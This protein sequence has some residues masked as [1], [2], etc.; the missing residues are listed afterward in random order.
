MEQIIGKLS[1]IETTAET[2]MKDATQKKKALSAEMERHSK[3]FDTQLE[4]QTEEQIQEIRRNLEG[5]KDKRLNSLRKDT[6]SA[7]NELDAYY[8]KNHER[9]SR[10]IF[11]KI[12]QEE[13]M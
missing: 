9:L 10:E 11:E 4:K 8:Q 5:E 3:E 6:Q 2:I 7:L 1:E 12:I 13:V